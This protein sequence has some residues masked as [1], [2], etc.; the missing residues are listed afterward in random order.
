MPTPRTL[1]PGTEAYQEAKH[2]EC[3]AATPAAAPL[4]PRNTIGHAMS[5]NGSE[6]GREALVGKGVHQGHLGQS[7]ARDGV[8][9]ITSCRHVVLLR[10]RVHDMVDGLHREVKRHE[11]EH[12]LEVLVGRS[13]GQPGGKVAE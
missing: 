1:R 6:N 10:S 4:G 9:E 12:R 8:R 7:W 2:C 5:I 11:L 3:C 13:H